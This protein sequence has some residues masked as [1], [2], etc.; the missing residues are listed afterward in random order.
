MVDMALR[1]TS[2]G[3]RALPWEDGLVVSD[4]SPDRSLWS[5]PAVQRPMCLAGRGPL[6]LRLSPL[7]P[8]L[9]G[10]PSCIDSSSISINLRSMNK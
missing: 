7:L 3:Q 5:E 8:R 1:L 4:R 9:A 6:A 10:F 2:G